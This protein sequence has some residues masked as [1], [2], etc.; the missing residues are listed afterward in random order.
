MEME[1]KAKMQLIEYEIELK[2]LEIE[3]K[4][5]EYKAKCLD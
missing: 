2:K 1:H 4:K 5:A 3:Y